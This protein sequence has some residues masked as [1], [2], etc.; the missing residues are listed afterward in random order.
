MMPKYAILGATGNAGRALVNLLS[1]SPE[2]SL[3]LY[4]RSKYK[5]QAQNPTLASSPP[6]NI[7]FFIGPIT[8]TETIASCIEDVDAVF[9]VVATNENEPSC[10]I[11]QDT[12]HAVLAAL[13]TLRRQKKGEGLPRLIFLSAAPVSN[14]FKAKMP[15]LVRWLLW[16]AYGNV[17]RDL[18]TAEALIRREREWLKVIYVYSGGLSSWDERIQ[19]H[20]HVRPSNRMNGVADVE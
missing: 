11:A 10:H 16:K 17:Y 8:N 9:C 15:A 18:E 6:P 12:A 19:G 1:V 2:I 5:L 14:V 4:A 3:N 13:E 20:R 7:K